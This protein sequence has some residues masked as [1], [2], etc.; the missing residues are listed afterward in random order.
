MSQVSH[1]RFCGNAHEHES[2]PHSEAEDGQPYSCPGYNRRHE[3]ARA[4]LMSDLLDVNIEMTKQHI[5]GNVI[6]T[7][8]AEIQP[9]SEDMLADMLNRQRALQ[10]QSYGFDF[11]AMSEEERVLFAKDQALALLDEVHEAL[12]EIGWKPW[13]TSRHMNRDAFVSEL[14]DAWHFLMNLLL[15]ARVTPEEFYRKYKAKNIK[16]ALRQYKGYDGVTDK[17]PS[18]KRAYDDDAVRCHVVEDNEPPFYWCEVNGEVP[19]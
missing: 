9:I 8:S 3:E 17:C 10:E 5:P 1:S 11:N 15:A 18:C 6:M 7:Q 4:R 19:A 13:A 16:N 14:V 12:G 2:H